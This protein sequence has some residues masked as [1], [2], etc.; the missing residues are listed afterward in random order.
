MRE[1]FPTGRRAAEGEP[2][3]LAVAA[4]NLAMSTGTRVPDAAYLVTAARLDVP[5]ISA[6]RTQL[7]A[8]I[9]AGI[10]AVPL[11]E[12]SALGG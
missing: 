8:A 4:F 2:H 1:R 12:V 9:A 3:G 10:D 6:D 7:E 11:N 5:L